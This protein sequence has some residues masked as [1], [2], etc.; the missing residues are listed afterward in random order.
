MNFKK[1]LVVYVLSV[2]FLATGCGGDSSEPSVPSNAV[3]ISSSN[4]DNVAYTVIGLA[5]TGSSL[6]SSDVKTPD[7]TSAINKVIE[8]SFDKNRQ[9]PS[10][11]RATSSEGCGS[12]SIDFTGEIDL[13]TG[14]V[15]TLIFNNCT[16]VGVSINGSF[17]IDSSW[18]LTTGQYTNIGSGNITIGIGGISFTMA[19]SYTETGNSGTGYFSTDISY[20]LSSSI[21]EGFL[22]TTAQNLIGN[23]DIVDQGQ[24]IVEGANNTRL[25]I[26]FNND[27]TATISLDSG[28]GLFVVFSIID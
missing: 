21:F 6:R 20:S 12:G 23:F 15:G 9:S 19:L 13:A 17:S 24:L 25:S 2:G 10:L 5:S 26:T 7:I 1:L 16:D 8:L 28:N 27:A 11:T 4:A 22:V 3:L 14:R 18:N